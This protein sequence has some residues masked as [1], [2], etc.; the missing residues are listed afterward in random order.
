M[1]HVTTAANAIEA[2]YTRV[3]GATAEHIAARADIEDR[4]Q[5][6]MVIVRSSPPARGGVAAFRRRGGGSDGIVRNLYATNAGKLVAWI[7]SQHVEKTP[8][9]KEP[10]TPTPDP[11][12]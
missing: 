5:Q 7:A 2:S 3:D 6:G 10:T 8:K 12:P 11:T 4:I 9:K 1:D